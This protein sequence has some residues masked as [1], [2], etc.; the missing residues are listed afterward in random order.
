MDS[1]VP[2]L[3]S[4]CYL[5]PPFPYTFSPFCDRHSF[6]SILTTI[7]LVTFTREKLKQYSGISEPRGNSRLRRGAFV[8]GL[9]VSPD[10]LKPGIHHGRLCGRSL[11]A[12]LLLSRF[13]PTITCQIFHPGRPAKPVALTLSG[14]KR[15]LESKASIRSSTNTSTKATIRDTKNYTDIDIETSAKTAAT[16]ITWATHVN[17]IAATTVN[18][19]I[20][21]TNDH[22]EEETNETKD[23]SVTIATTG[24]RD[25]KIIARMNG[26]AVS[27]LRDKAIILA[28]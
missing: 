22:D 4:I 12:F 13:S 28:P 23:I 26:H 10:S 25:N 21:T 11:A 19:M 24:D 2:Y 8:Q 3:R 17:V 9:V 16:E 15:N 7:I 5:L 1:S 20:A 6:A 18:Q 27:L 14:L